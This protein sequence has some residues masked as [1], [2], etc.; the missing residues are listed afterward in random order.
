M[1]KQDITK[2]T[3]VDSLDKFKREVKLL[4]KS[5]SEV[6][7]ILTKINNEEIIE[8]VKENALDNLEG[9]L[10]DLENDLDEI[11]YNLEETKLSDMSKDF[12]NSLIEEFKNY[13]YTCNDLEETKEQLSEI[14]IY[15]TDHI[16][17][18]PIKAKSMNVKSKMKNRVKELKNNNIEI[19][20]I[21]SM[22][23]SEFPNENSVNIRTIK[24]WLKNE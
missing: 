21:I 12:Y 20:D 11:E 2:D 10:N 8:L 15:N 3:I 18:K 24:R 6:E 1:Y 13:L 9:Y 4:I 17:E 5:I 19:K 22:L 14:E 23:K 16:K 7:L